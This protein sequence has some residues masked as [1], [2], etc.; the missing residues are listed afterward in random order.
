MSLPATSPSSQEDVFPQK[1]LLIWVFLF[2][3]LPFVIAHGFETWSRP[4]VDFPPLYCATK[5]VFDYGQT[6]YG[7]D[8]FAAQAMAIGRPIPPFIYPPPSLL[9]LFPLHY[10]DYDTA[11]ALMLVAN[12]LCLLFATG[13]ILLKL[14]PDVFARAPAPLSAALILIYIFLFDPTVVTLHLGQVNLF[15]LVCICLTWEA[16]RKER[17]AL[18]VAI[19]LSIAIAIKTY[20]VLLLPVLV[21][22]R[23][24]KAAAW[25]VAL[26]GLY[27]AASYWLMPQY[28]WHDW[29]TKVL[30]TGG[31]AH[32]G[33]WNQNIRAF[34]A[35]AFQPNEFSE[36]LL[37]WPQG[38]KPL[39]A[40][41]TLGITAV[42]LWV[43]LRHWRAPFRRENV[44]QL[45]SLFLLLIFLIA[46]VS[47]EHHFV[48]L[49]PSLALLIL[50]LLSG[51]VWG[52]WRWVIAL[53]LCLI[54][55]KVPMTAPGLKHGF[56]T[57]L[58]SAKFY[59]AV[60]LWVFFAVRS[61]QC[62][63]SPDGTG[64]AALGEK[65]KTLHSR[66]TLPSVTVS[67]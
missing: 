40:L 61:L 67:A 30:P 64:A 39:I 22:S 16:L 8:A 18:A 20:P 43:G 47:W 62:T 17:G 53:S 13:F 23:R 49:L 3:Y 35:R 11:K 44:D 29:L 52:H 31:D 59:P 54:A 56:W 33:P 38:V 46:P 51:E 58:I 14:F 15:L 60:A 45:F 9:V 66:D 41:L 24:Y 26:F 65:S 12:H 1:S 32:A 57:L 6:P 5:A 36:P 19:P 25:T 4:A 2:A 37:V 50:H 55:W 10:F 28:I 42:T 21:C 7:P 27:C 63:K 34:V 48:Y